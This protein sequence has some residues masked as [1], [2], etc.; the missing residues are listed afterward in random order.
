[1]GARPLA[2]VIQEQIKKP[3]A[4][5]VLFGKLRKGGTVR[6]SVAKDEAGEDAL[7]LDAIADEVPVRPKKEEPEGRPVKRKPA[8]K[9][10]ARA[11]PKAKEAPKRSIVPQLPR[12]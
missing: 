12:K 8:K 1:M 6:V 5:E 2:R 11:A 3:L 4:D 10:A 9:P 7:K